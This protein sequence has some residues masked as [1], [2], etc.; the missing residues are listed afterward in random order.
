MGSHTIKTWSR[1]QSVVALSSGEAEY[2]AIV[3]GSAEG[4]GIQAIA[5]DMGLEWCLHVSTDASAAIGI[6]S[7]RLRVH[8]SRAGSR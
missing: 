3:K 5:A 8:I 4:L 1:M 7:R 6:G 2:Y